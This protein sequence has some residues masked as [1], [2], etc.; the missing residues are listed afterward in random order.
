MKNTEMLEIPEEAYQEL[1][2]TERKYL[3]LLEEFR[4]VSKSLED[5]SES[6]RSFFEKV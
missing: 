1:V 6:L 3:I 4:K 5:L 2:E